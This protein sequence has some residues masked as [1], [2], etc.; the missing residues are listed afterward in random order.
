[1]SAGERGQVELAQPVRV[2]DHV[3]RRNLPGG[4]G[5][6]KDDERPAPIM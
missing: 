2:G 1:M 4:E 6:P 5:E 3:D